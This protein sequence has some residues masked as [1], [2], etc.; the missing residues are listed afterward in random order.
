MPSDAGGRETHGTA[1]VPADIPLDIMAAVIYNIRKKRWEGGF[2]QRDG[3]ALSVAEPERAFSLHP[4]GH[5][6]ATIARGDR[7]SG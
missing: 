5:A 2:I 6:G 3:E 7:W 1:C 4:R